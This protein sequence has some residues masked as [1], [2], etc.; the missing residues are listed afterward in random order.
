MLLTKEMSDEMKE[1]IEAIIDFEKKSKESD[2]EDQQSSSS[3]DDADSERSARP[4]RA[5]ASSASRSSSA[6]AP[7]YKV[8]IPA[9]Q[10]EAAV[11]RALEQR[12]L[13]TA[14]SAAR[15]R[16]ASAAAGRARGA[17]SHSDCDTED[18]DDDAPVTK[19]DLRD[20][21]KQAASASQT[22]HARAARA[23]LVYTTNLGRWADAHEQGRLPDQLVAWR[24]T[25][26]QRA[27]SDV[28]RVTLGVLAGA[29]ERAIGRAAAD[30]GPDDWDL[31]APLI[32][33]LLS[34]E[35][36]LQAYTRAPPTTHVNFIADATATLAA[37]GERLWERPPSDL[38]RTVDDSL[39]SLRDA[40]GLSPPRGR[41]NGN[42]V[43]RRGGHAPAKGRRRGQRDSRPYK[44][45]RMAD[46]KKDNGGG[47]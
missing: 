19:R 28:T 10:L 34:A 9:A 32:A 18:D 25:A 47:Q 20:M 7:V 40:H 30:P 42:L 23:P 43:P 41:G 29:I 15:S 37:E 46:D 24:S 12:G 26:L 22:I 45:P 11:S 39:R 1:L 6:A 14:S 3:S 27:S 2:H 38:Q 44:Q 33:E 36:A 13:G 17:T 21:I 35:A 4:A 31:L 16:G 8:K 5:A